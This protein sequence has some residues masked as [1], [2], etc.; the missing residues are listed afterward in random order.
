[1]IVLIFANLVQLDSFLPVARS[2][3]FAVLLLNCCLTDMLT[4]RLRRVQFHPSPKNSSLP[5]L[6]S[7][8]ERRPLRSHVKTWLTNNS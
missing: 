3:Y 1:M 8:R 5:F 2:R 6:N 7:S 4:S